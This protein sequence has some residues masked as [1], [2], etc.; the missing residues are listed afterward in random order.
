MKTEAQLLIDLS[1]LQGKRL[2]REI[3]VRKE[4]IDYPDH[5]LVKIV[6]ENWD[7]DEEANNRYFN[8]MT[9]KEKAVFI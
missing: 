2:G 5:E 8:Q 1:V 3:Q 4:Y 9:E 6:K 7:D